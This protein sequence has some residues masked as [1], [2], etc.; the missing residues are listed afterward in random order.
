M[1]GRLCAPLGRE[2]T[3]RGARVLVE[4]QEIVEYAPFQEDGV[5]IGVREVSGL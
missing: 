2:T 1:H 4:A 3:L 5:G